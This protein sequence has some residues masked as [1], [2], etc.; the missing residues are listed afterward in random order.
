MERRKFI[1]LEAMKLIEECG[2]T[3]VQAARI[4]ACRARCCA[5]RGRECA[6]EFQQAFP[7]QGQMKPEHAELARLRREVIKVMAER[8]LLEK[9]AVGLR[10]RHREVRL[11]C[12]APRNLAAEMVCEAQPSSE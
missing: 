6:V 5:G 4:L 1:K 9:A 11:Q 7:C 12:E 10:R 3:M 2:V 8:E